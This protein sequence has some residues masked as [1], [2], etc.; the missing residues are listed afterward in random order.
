[1]SSCWAT[2]LLG[3]GQCCSEP[4]QA[5]AGGRSSTLGWARC[6]ARANSSL[7]EGFLETTHMLLPLTSTLLGPERLGFC[8]FIPSLLSTALFPGLKVVYECIPCDNTVTFCPY[9]VVPFNLFIYFLPLKK[10][11]SGDSVCKP[12][13]IRPLCTCDKLVVFV[14]LLMDLHNCTLLVQMLKKYCVLFKIFK[15]YQQFGG[16]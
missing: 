12:Y 14:S 13:P 15:T 4:G 16:N 6:G 2:T 9:C 1:M 5:G 3:A 11:R 8:W 10:A 7:T